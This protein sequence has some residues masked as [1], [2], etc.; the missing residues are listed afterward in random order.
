MTKVPALTEVSA[1]LTELRD[2][3]YKIQLAAAALRDEL[4]MLS[5]MPAE[6]E[7]SP[8]LAHD[9][10]VADLLGRAR[11]VA[12]TGRRERIGEIQLQLKIYDAASEQLT[13]EINGEEGKASAIIRGR[14]QP[15]FDRRLKALCAALLA[16]QRANEELREFRDALDDQRISCA[17]SMLPDLREVLG[18]PRDP[19]AAGNAYFRGAV[20]VGL[21]SAS[22]LPT[23]AR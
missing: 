20:K 12:P 9:A 16:A 19:H 11:P 14:M 15:E 23:G 10:A 17:S 13:S 2:R 18:N 4:F 21:M 8:T 1:V 3:R 6:Q 22:D 5:R 7:W